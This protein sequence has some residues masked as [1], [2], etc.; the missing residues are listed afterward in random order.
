MSEI[1]TLLREKSGEITDGLVKQA[2]A[3]EFVAQT[4]SAAIEALVAQG[5]SAQ[6][7]G[8]LVKSAEELQGLVPVVSV[9]LEH[10]ADVL[11]KAAAYIEHLEQRD[12][13]AQVKLQIGEELSKEASLSVRQET[14]VLSG[15]GFSKDEVKMLSEIG[16]LE[17]VA[18]VST[19]P[20]DMGQSSGRPAADSLD[21][22][23]KFC[24]GL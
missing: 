24:L 6:D 19:V 4:Q 9:D 23:A 2:E 3:N 13:E 11:E 16:L 22:L 17:K 7:A 12:S 1:A 21:P 5:I 8:D 18:N 10:I 15:V 14:E 20:W